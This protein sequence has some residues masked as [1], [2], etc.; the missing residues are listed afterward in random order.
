MRT[1]PTVP[2]T[3][4]SVTAE[5][6]RKAATAFTESLPEWINGASAADIY[7]LRVLIASHRASQIAVAGATKAAVPLQTFAQSKFSEALAGMLPS[8]RTLNELQWRRKIRKPVGHSVPYLEDSFDVHPALSRLMQNFAED[9]IPFSD[10]G[11]VVQVDDEGVIGNTA[12]LIETCRQLDVGKQYQALLDEHF[13]QNKALLVADKLAGF[14]LA[15]HVAFLKGKIDDD[16]RAALEHYAES[17][18]GTATEPRLTAYPGLMSMLEVLVH[19]ALIIQLKNADG[20]S[21]GV[22]TYMPGDADNPLRWHSSTRELQAEMVSALQHQGYQRELLQLIALDARNAFFQQLQL[23]LMDE[24][25]DLQIEGTTGHGTV[26]TRWVDEQVERVRADARMLLVPTADADAEASRKRLDDWKS[27]GWG[28]V[29]LAG[30]FIPAVGAVLLG[31][32]LKDVCAQVFEGVTDWAKGHDHEA[33]QHA[34]N[35]A[36]V[37]VATGAAVVAGAAVGRLVNRA[38]EDGLEAVTLDDDSQGLWNGDLSIY[39]RELPDDAVMGADGLYF[40]GDRRWLRVDEHY[41]EVHQPSENGAWRLLHPDRPHAYGPVLQRNAERLWLLPDDSPMN[42]E[43]PQQMLARLWPQQ[44]PLDQHRAE[45]VLQAACSDVDELRGILVENRPLP[46]NLRDTLRRFEA[47]QRIERFF[48]SLAPGATGADDPVLLDWCEKRPGLAQLKA[49]DRPGA[50]LD[51]Q[52]KLRHELFDHLTSV[53]PSSDP[54]VQVLQRDFPGLPTDYAIELACQVIGAEREEVELVQRLPLPVSN[55]ARSLLQL[56]RLNRAVQGVMLRNAYSD[57]SG[58]LALGLLSRLGHWSFSRR[59]EL[60]IGTA[61]GRLL[62]AINTQAAESDQITM[63]RIAGVFQLYDAQGLKLPEQSSVSDDFFQGIVTVLTDEQ[64]TALGLGSEDQAGELRRQVVKLLPKGRQKLAEQLSWRE[65]LGW[66]NPGQRLEDGRVG[67]TLGG[68]VSQLR[69]P[70]WRVRR[71]LGRLYQGDTPRQ[72]DEHLNRILDAANPYAALIQEEQNYHMLD[73]CLETWIS[74]GAGG[75][76]AARRMLARRLLQAW[77]RQ[78][79]ID[80]QENAVRGFVLDL[81][82]HRVTSLPRLD[83]AIDFHH[84]TSLTM[85]NTPL[86]VAPDA[87]FSCFRHVRRLNMAR[88]R[89]EALPI[90]IRHLRLLERLDLSY[91]GIRNGDRVSEALSSLTGL[92]DLNLSFNPSIRSLSLG[93]WGTSLRRLSLRLCGLLEWPAGLQ[94]CRLLRWIDLSSNNLTSVP[95]AIQAMPYS[96]RISIL[97]DRNAIDASQ[98]ARLYERPAP[99]HPP[100]PQPAPALLSAK[101]VWVAGEHAQARGA[102]WDRLFAVPES[103]ELK[104]ILG[105]LQQSSDYRNQAYRSELDVRVWTLLDAMAADTTLESDVHAH[106]MGSVTCADDVADRFSELHL[107]ALV[108]N[109]TRSAAET[110][111]Q[112]ALLD[113]G[114]GLFRLTLLNEHVGRYIAE[115]AVSAPTLDA[116]EVSLYFRVALAE[117]MKLPSQPK[118]MLFGG[119]ANVSEADLDAARA[120]VRTRATVEA[121]AAFLSQQ[122]FWIEWLKKQRPEEFTPVEDQFQETMNQL[123]ERRAEMTF[124]QFKEQ[125]DEVGAKLEYVKNRLVILL[126]TPMLT[127]DADP[128]LPAGDQTGHPD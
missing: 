38:M 116:V 46:A 114:Q 53:E 30:F 113:L 93:R 97:L 81:S 36:Q 82:G 63:V 83:A 27:L 10:S 32:L 33:L 25:P 70:G 9:D 103:Q 12:Q 94:E 45:Q 64:K 125:S 72:I 112:Q 71:R 85:V 28:L 40:K 84:I 107:L 80:V 17:L 41:Y 22:V 127:P 58:E 104:T 120:C 124:P 56:A 14:R 5:D 99:V 47:D 96:Y 78:L 69:E 24:V 11:L 88:N 73:Q 74:D 67:Y 66:F 34:L 119:I 48:R 95:A 55:K 18:S 106:A 87:F 16:V 108:N 35:V 59:L 122:K 65:E 62:A 77:R 100:A 118:S 8:G 49:A 39:Q 91:N 42:W 76:Q 13:T 92:Q 89:L 121:K 4:N 61:E 111:Q 43:D 90:G 20:K 26:F 68:R 3:R 126:T 19:E 117:E 110:D 57:S 15:V 105:R 2:S 6:M 86:Q 75:E 79:P 1:F 7:K 21:A 44:R 23:R 29:G 54:V 60:R 50:I 123:F 98:L 37:V 109:A 128:I 115:K 51:Q 31:A 52:I 102:T 101:A